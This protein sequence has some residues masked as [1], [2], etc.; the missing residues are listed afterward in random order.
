MPNFVNSQ[1]NARLSVVIVVA[2]GNTPR[3][4]LGVFVA[5]WEVALLE[6][7]IVNRSAHGA[8]L[9]DYEL[10]DVLHSE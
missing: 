7:V 9:T 8:S 3:N 6:G 10:G 4:E 5:R 1:H 2:N